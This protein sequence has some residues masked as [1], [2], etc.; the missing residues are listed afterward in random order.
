MNKARVKKNIAITLILLAVIG[1]II[2]TLCSELV[3]GEDYQ[4]K[5]YATWVALLPPLIAIVL[6]LVTKEVYF[7]LL[8]G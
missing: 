8:I 6:A 7:S 4:S 2:Y 1:L 3:V 5:F